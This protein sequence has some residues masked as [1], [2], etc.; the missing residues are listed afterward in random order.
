MIYCIQF[1][2]K[3]NPSVQESRPTYTYF[4]FGGFTRHLA[5]FFNVTGVHS[6]TGL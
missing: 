5:V 3:F 1:I 6:I 2:L 4:G